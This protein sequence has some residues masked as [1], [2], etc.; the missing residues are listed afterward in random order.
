LVLMT[1]HIHLIV[2][3]QSE[4]ALPRTMKRLGERYVYYF[5]RKNARTGTLWGGRHRA[6]LLLD[7]LYCLTCLR[8]VE[9]N[10]VRAKMVSRP[11]EYRW[12]TYGVHALGAAPDWLVPHPVYLALGSTAADR[13]AAYRELCGVMLTEAQLASVRHAEV[14]PIGSIGQSSLQPQP[15]LART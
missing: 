12:S 5:N 10:P 1:T 13:Q 9:Q 7:E 3:P 8:Y 11:E 2:T 14:A 4:T 15:E 6:L